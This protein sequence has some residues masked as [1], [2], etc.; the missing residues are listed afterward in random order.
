MNS[1]RI[2]TGKLKKKKFE[3]PLW[4][5]QRRCFFSTGLTVKSC[6]W[7]LFPTS[8]HAVCGCSIAT[9]TCGRSRVGGSCSC[10]GG[11]CSCGGGSCS[12]DGR[13][14]PEQSATTGSRRQCCWKR[15][16]SQWVSPS[17]PPSAVIVTE[18]TCDAVAAGPMRST[19]MSLRQSTAPATASQLLLLS[20]SLTS[21]ESYKKFTI[22][23]DV[24][25]TAC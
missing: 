13:P 15:L 7:Q 19:T 4:A 20:Q 11:S 25:K 10:G 21:T 8:K 5:I 23:S 18:V 9:S 2:F 16:L 24:I 3:Q 22:T 12:C 1:L 17:H 6:S 14:L